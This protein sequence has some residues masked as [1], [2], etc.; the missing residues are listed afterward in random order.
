SGVALSGRHLIIHYS[1]FIIHLNKKR[2]K[3]RVPIRQYPLQKRAFFP[4]LQKNDRAG[5]S[6]ALS[7]F[8]VLE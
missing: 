2:P 7:F 1:S 4:I 3:G 5:D 6:L 8:L